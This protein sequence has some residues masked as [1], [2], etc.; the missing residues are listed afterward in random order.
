MKRPKIEMVYIDIDGVLGRWQL[1]EVSRQIGRKITESEWP[2]H[3]GWDI[4]STIH[5]LGGKDYRTNPMFFWAT[6]TEESWST[7]PKT[8]HFDS[9][10]NGSIA[11][12][13]QENIRICTA[14]PPDHNPAAYSGKA[15]WIK[16]NLP[17]WLH[18]NVIFTEHKHELALPN[19]LLIDDAD[20]NFNAWAT[21]GGAAILIPRPWNRN[22]GADIDEMLEWYFAAMSIR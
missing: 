13:G 8:E 5:E 20:H 11:L 7:A 18:R 21:A 14:P 15:I 4:I 19:R 22:H 12:V 9:I 17:K 10:L 16:K 6:V 2:L 3:H 1:H